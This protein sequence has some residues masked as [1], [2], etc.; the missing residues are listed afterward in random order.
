LFFSFPKENHGRRETFP[1]GESDLPVGFRRKRNHGAAI[2]SARVCFA[3]VRLPIVYLR[4]LFPNLWPG[5][6]SAL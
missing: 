6:S 4:T 1:A 3:L 5:N 2:S